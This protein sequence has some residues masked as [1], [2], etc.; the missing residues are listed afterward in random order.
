MDKEVIRKFYK[1][2]RFKINDFLSESQTFFKED[3]QEI[4][5]F[6]KGYEKELDISKIKKL[7]KLSEECIEITNLFSLNKG[8]MRTSDFWELLDKIED[9]K[10]KLKYS[11]NI[12]KYLRS[13]I[14]SK[15]DKSGFRFDYSLSNQQTLESVTQNILEERNWESEWINQAKDNDLKEE[16]WDIKG[17]KN[18]I[19]NKRI[20]QSNLVTTIIDNTI[21]KRIYGKDIKR[22]L[23]Y[24]DDD[25]L[26]LDYEKTALQSARI[27][28][29]LNKRD[30]PEFPNLGLDLQLYK[31]SNFSQMNYASISR[32]MKRNFATDDLFI[33]FE[34]KDLKHEEGD[35]IIEY[36][37]NTKHELVILQ[38]VSL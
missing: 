10:S 14:I 38:N 31:G 2:T 30:I 37:V 18:L 32:E 17:N 22:I 23:E 16:D 20:F 25:L 36:E 19:L 26:I 27:L 7:N 21:G 6:F 9:I 1:I 33:D 4:I 35:L 24:E 8:V 3:L 28:S 11:Q 13:S 12:S 15:A 34:I 5:K 29:S